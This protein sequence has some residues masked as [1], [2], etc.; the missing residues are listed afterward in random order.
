MDKNKIVIF[1]GAGISAESGLQTFRD[2]G[3]LWHN[4]KVSEVCT[5]EAW[6]DN[7]ERVLDFYN[8]RRRN[9]ADAEPN[10][11]HRAIAELE[12]QFQVVVI[13]QNI[14]DLHER[15][16]STQVLHVHGEITRARSSEDPSLIYELGYR[17]IKMGDLCDRG[18]QLRPHIVW[19]GEEVFELEESLYHIQSAS[20][21]LVV[22]TSLS[23]FPVA[24]LV[25][26]APGEAEKVIVSLDVE[27]TPHDYQLYRER[28]SE[29]VPQL[30]SQWL[31]DKNA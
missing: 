28:A 4:Y 11:A 20:R 9:V 26:E 22:G 8:Q 31:V 10:A 27:A 24:A 21:V 6:Q 7:P 13:T 1:S 15:A 3:G 12:S 5:P 30:V 25:H 19:F 2:S 17:D 14:D 18:S 23:V 16:G 29:K